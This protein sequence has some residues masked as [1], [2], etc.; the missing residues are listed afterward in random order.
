MINTTKK[1]ALAAGLTAASLSAEGSPILCNLESINTP[2][3]SLCLGVDADNN[4]I[5]FDLT[6]SNID[7]IQYSPK[8]LSLSNFDD[9][10]NFTQ[11]SRIN[12]DLSSQ[13]DFFNPGVA[14]HFARN[15]NFDNNLHLTLNITDS[16][17]DSILSGDIG[18]DYA[19]ALGHR[20]GI[21]GDR[22]TGK[23]FYTP[24]TTNVPEPSTV[25]ML[26]LGLIGLANSKRN[27]KQNLASSLN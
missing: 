20:A 23:A 2:E 8:L 27:K 14:N 15:D 6:T 25:V 22:L 19:A 3:Y 4:R 7:P 10:L 1:L 5:D 9:F 26:G 18:L 21:F 16:L 24:E 12:Y 11:N 17:R 13:G